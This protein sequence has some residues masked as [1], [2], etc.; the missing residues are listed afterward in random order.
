MIASA[1][2]VVAYLGLLVGLQNRWL[3]LLGVFSIGLLPR[4]VMLA[5]CN[6]DDIGAIFS[7]TLV[8]SS[9]LYYRKHY[10]RTRAYLAVPASLGLL[11]LSKFSAWLCLPIVGIYLLATPF[12][13]VLLSVKKLLLTTLLFLAFGGWWLIFNAVNYGIDDPTGLGN[14]RSIQE[15]RVDLPANQRG[16]LTVGV[17]LSG[18]LSNYDQFL[19]K[20]YKSTIGY[21]Q[22]LK[23][24]MSKPIYLFYSAL[25]VIAVG[26]AFVCSARGFRHRNY[27]ELMLLLS[28]VMQI[29]F[30]FHHNLVRDQQPQGRYILPMI[31]PLV[32]L[33]L[34][35]LQN[36][37][38]LSMTFSMGKK[39]VVMSE[40]LAVFLT[41]V[42]VLL[43][44]DNHFNYVR[45]IYQHDSHQLIA[46]RS[47][48][49]DLVNLFSPRTESNIASSV[50]NDSIFLRRQGEG[51]AYAIVSPKLCDFIDDNSILTLTVE[52]E[53]K[54]GM[55]VMLDT[56]GDGSYENKIWQSFRGQ[57]Q[58]TLVFAI[59]NKGCNSIKI[60]LSKS[61]Q[62]LL[63]S[64]AEVRKLMM[65]R[66]G[67]PIIR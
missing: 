65:H 32:Y 36:L 56:F 57:G 48:T 14:A 23:L 44:F 53:S 49:L 8:I 55:Y 35:W 11:I 5:S 58:H 50:Q 1:T 13:N 54:G 27:F 2:L 15:T 43:H 47:K 41:A 46:A 24:D 45:P 67:L 20:S 66:H 62:Q 17:G 18:L 59:Q 60:S 61:L 40:P 64:K 25:F 33:F 28:I 4:F 34:L 9:L 63:I 7:V 52:A 3:A 26:Y 37:P 51:R 31:L 38:K 10:A 39:N 29:A 21:I 6:N 19:T 42:L 30:Y 12:R 22:W 16:Y